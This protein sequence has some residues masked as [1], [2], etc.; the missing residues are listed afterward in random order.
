MLTCKNKKLGVQHFVVRD[1]DL[2]AT[3]CFSVIMAYSVSHPMSEKGCE[4]SHLLQCWELF[5][6]FIG[7]FSSLIISHTRYFHG[8]DCIET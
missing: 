2:L 3:Y 1:K 5:H 4:E 8:K 7:S 6:I